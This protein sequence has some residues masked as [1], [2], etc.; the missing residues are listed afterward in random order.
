MADR[1]WNRGA[2]LGKSPKPAPAALAPQ[3]QPGE[4]PGQ[5][6]GV[7]SRGQAEEMRVVIREYEGRPYV[8]LQVYSEGDGG[9]MV[10][11]RWKSSTVR[12][13][14]LGGVI[15][16]L[17]KA[18]R[19]LGGGSAQSSTLKPGPRSSRKAAESAPLFGVENPGAPAAG[20][21]QPAGDGDDMPF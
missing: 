9:E 20:W 6:M 10:A 13:R 4:D 11:V 19:Q 17:Q 3:G 16:A 1:K 12:V 18:E 14:E 5:V 8:A 2:Y 7:F 21:V 15:S